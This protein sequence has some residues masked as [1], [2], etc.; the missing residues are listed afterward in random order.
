VSHIFGALSVLKMRHAFMLLPSNSDFQGP[1]FAAAGWIMTAVSSNAII[2]VMRVGI[3]RRQT[4]DVEEKSKRNAA[5]DG[6]VSA[7]PVVRRT[8]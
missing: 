6:S 7:W 2:G 1:A 8:D 3:P 5:G 4:A